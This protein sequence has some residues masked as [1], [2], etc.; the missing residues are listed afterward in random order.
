MSNTKIVTVESFRPLACC[1]TT[2]RLKMEFMRYSPKQRPAPACWIL[3]VFLLSSVAFSSENTAW[4]QRFLPRES[5]Q[6]AVTQNGLRSTLKPIVQVVRR[7]VY[8]TITPNSQLNSQATSTLP[9]WRAASPTMVNPPL[10]SSAQSPASQAP[11]WTTTDL[12]TLPATESRLLPSVN[13]ATIVSST[14]NNSAIPNLSAGNGKWYP[15][16]IARG[17]DRDRIK[18]MPIE[19]R[20]NRPFHFYGNTVRRNLNRSTTTSRRFLQR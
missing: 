15:Y 19:Q 11:N 16:V 6:P 13:P 7:P 2:N 9:P 17:S 3:T 18:E 1:W 8:P 12:G 5:A 20:P 4:G 14:G 10:I